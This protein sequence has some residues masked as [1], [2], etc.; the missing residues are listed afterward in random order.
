LKLNPSITIQ[1]ADWAT[2]TRSNPLR[3]VDPAN[4][5]A[6]LE[7]HERGE[8]GQSA[9]FFDAIL[10]RDDTL[11][12]VA[13]KR[14]GAVS[15]RSWEVTIPAE[16]AGNPA[17]EEQKAEIEYLLRNI[18]VTDALNLDYSGGF[19]SLVE[20][21]VKT[22]FYGRGLAELVWR[23]SI[24]GMGLEVRRVPLWFTEATTGKLR[25]K[26]SPM[27]TTG[28]DCVP[29]EWLVT[30][31]DDCLLYAASVLFYEKSTARKDRLLFSFKF[32]VPGLLIQTSASPG[33]DEWDQVVEAAAE[34]ASDMVGVFPNGTTATA[35]NSGGA[36]GAPMDVIIEDAKRALVMLF[37]GSDLSTMS[38]ADGM[39]ASLQGGESATLETSDADY[40]CAVLNRDVVPYVLQW[41]LGTR[42]RLV[43]I[44]LPAPEAAD[45]AKDIQIDQHLQLM[46]VAQDKAD[47]AERYGRTI[48]Q[49]NAPASPPLP[50]SPAPPPSAPQAP[51]A[52][53]DQGSEQEA[54]E[55][56][57]PLSFKD[58][59]KKIAAALQE[60]LKPLA[61]RLAAMARKLDAS[62][63]EPLTDADKKEL[64]A[65]LAD[66]DGAE[67]PAATVAAFEEFFAEALLQ[68]W[69]A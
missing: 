18:E 44:R 66:I 41:R 17:A 45:V 46:G 56:T 27:Q 69:S 37:R 49:A 34:I 25:W 29:G 1:A 65:L 16:H 11:A 9:L 7:Q 10:R 31:H 12:T 68:G 35:L 43:E 14:L 61:E 26:S 2:R 54:T 24:K 5:S 23:P 47:M 51:L 28:S 64:K 22:R 62:S 42:E 57:E 48:E 36:T 3:Y 67:L 55:G 21:I 63:T 33:S 50:G 59:S 19:E 58:A 4:V 52:N 30:A 20:H 32:G 13:P 15:S 8:Y 38:S 6:W 39:G 60:D 40:A 53:A